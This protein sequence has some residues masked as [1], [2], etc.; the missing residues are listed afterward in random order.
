LVRWFGH[1]IGNGYERRWGRLILAGCP[2]RRRCKWCDAGLVGVAPIVDDG[3]TVKS[4]VF[5]GHVGAVW[6]SRI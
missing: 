2:R 6:D 4:V 1:R 5:I 3:Q